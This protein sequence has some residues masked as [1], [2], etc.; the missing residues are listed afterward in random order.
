MC[1]IHGTHEKI[2]YINQQLKHTNVNFKLSPISEL[3]AAPV[4]AYWYAKVQQYV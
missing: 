1:N 4:V 2:M 3:L